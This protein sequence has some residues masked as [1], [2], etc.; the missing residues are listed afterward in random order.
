[1]SDA[2][3]KPVAVPNLYPG[4]ITYVCNFRFMSYP[5]FVSGMD[6]ARARRLAK[7]LPNDGV[8]VGE[9]IGWRFWEV[10]TGKETRLRSVFM[11]NIWE[12]GVPMTGIEPD[13]HGTTGVYAF[14]TRDQAAKEFAEMTYPSGMAM[15]S[16]RLW[17][18]VIEHE[19]GYRAQFAAVDEI[20]AVSTDYRDFKRGFF[21]RRSESKLLNHLRALYT[22]D[23]TYAD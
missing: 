6:E 23:R 15:G 18:T 10:V 7:P 5:I 17:G 8:K 20:V 3:E 16:V 19:I 22:P 21:R 1:M 9:V 12:P 11:D 13:D 14:H 2:T 4:G